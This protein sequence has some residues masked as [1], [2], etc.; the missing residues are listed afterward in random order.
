M[1][2]I[3]ILIYSKCKSNIIFA[4]QI[5]LEGE[6]AS[7]AGITTDIAPGTALWDRLNID[8]RSHELRSKD[9]KGKVVEERNAEYA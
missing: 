4:N 9:C 2:L 7:L 3:N 1:F 5:L 6:G 8:K